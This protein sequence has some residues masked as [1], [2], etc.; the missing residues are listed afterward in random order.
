MVKEPSH[1]KQLSLNHVS[2]IG[3]N[4]IFDFMCPNFW[5]AGNTALAAAAYKENPQSNTNKT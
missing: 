5:S 4:Q 3:L 1:E 2:K